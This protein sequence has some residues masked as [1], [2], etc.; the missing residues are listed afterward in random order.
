[1]SEQSTFLRYY[2]SVLKRNPLIRR[3]IIAWLLLPIPFAMWWS[4]FNWLGGVSLFNK[5]V[6]GANIAA[7]PVELV[8]LFS[9]LLGTAAAMGIVVVAPV[10]YFWATLRREK[11]ETSTTSNKYIFSDDLRHEN[12]LLREML[13]S[14]LREMESRHKTEHSL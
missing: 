14:L 11:G 6:A 7:D 8:R 3:G 1:M 2:E 13:G 5:A 12:A 4:W 9:A 10:Y